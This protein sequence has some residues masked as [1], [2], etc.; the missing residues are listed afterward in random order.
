MKHKLN[1]KTIKKL[2]KRLFKEVNK[3]YNKPDGFYC[4]IPEF[5]FTNLDGSGGVYVIDVSYGF[6]DADGNDVHRYIDEMFVARADGKI[7]I[8]FV[9]GQVIQYIVDHE[10]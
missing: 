7:E 3:E 9:A 1:S 5:A 2:E 6:K 8:P 10:W 4:Y